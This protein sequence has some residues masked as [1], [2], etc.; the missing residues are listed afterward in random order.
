MR[1]LENILYD[2]HVEFI[3]SDVWVPSSQCTKS[4]CP[5]S[6]FIEKDSSSLKQTKQA[7]EVQ[8][9]SGSAVGIAAYDTLTINSF[10]SSNQALGLVTSAKGFFSSGTNSTDK[11]SGILGLGFQG[12]L[13]NP[14]EE[15]FITN[16]VKNKVIDE[17][18][19]SIYLNKQGNYGYTGEIVLG[20]YETDRLMGGIRFLPVVNYDSTT[21]KANIGRSFRNSN[22][23]KLYKYWTVAGQAV[24]S[25]LSDGTKL[26][27]SQFND[28]QP[29]ILDTGTT[30][31][32]LAEDTVVSL[33]RT[34]TSNYKPLALNEGTVQAY[35]VNCSDFLSQDIWFDFQFSTSISDFST[36]PVVIRVPL[37]EL[38]LPQDTDSIDT[39]KTCLFGLA[40]ISDSFVASVGRGWILGQTVLRSAYVVHDMLGLQ[41]GIGAAANGYN[42]TTLDSGGSTVIITHATSI[43]VAFC[44]ILVLL[45]INIPSFMSK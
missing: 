29:V 6:L 43:S 39:A 37:K 4:M 16:L 14:N 10:T 26:Y 38:A 44:I 35:Q 13:R 9:G 40:P 1:M 5:H 8:Y 30:L 3:S 32:Y 18:V 42:L 23:S 7:F 25:Y 19:F 22:S 15:T 27:E 2:Q 11:A 20:G 34:I 33:L 36:S 17:P 31:S 21:G 24:L 12:L 41:I 45:A 28:I